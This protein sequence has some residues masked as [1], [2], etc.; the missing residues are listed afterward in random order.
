ML[1]TFKVTLVYIL[2]K[3]KLS[4]LIKLIRILFL[5]QKE[6]IKKFTDIWNFLSNCRN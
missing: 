6:N 2:Y 3:Y 5:F 1:S 4:S